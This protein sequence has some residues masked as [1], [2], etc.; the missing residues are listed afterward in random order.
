MLP[1]LVYCSDLPRHYYIVLHN[2]VEAHCH[3]VE[4]TSSGAIDELFLI[5]ICH[6]NCSSIPHLK[7][8]VLHIRGS[9]SIVQ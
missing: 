6:M 3:V 2:I 1:I 9:E 8:I 5:P 7:L 4:L